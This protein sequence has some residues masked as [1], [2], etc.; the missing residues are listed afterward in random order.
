ML[1]SCKGKR[2]ELLCAFWVSCSYWVLMGCRGSVQG[3]G[4]NG[5]CNA[6]FLQREEGGTAFGLLGF[7]HTSCRWSVRG[8]GAHQPVGA[9]AGRGQWDGLDMVIL[10]VLSYLNDPRIAWFC[11]GCE[12]AEQ[13]M[14]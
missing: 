3:W 11:G 10:K 12:A 6:L 14:A 1:S 13:R 8:L 2:A 7:T 9:T 5:S 4:A